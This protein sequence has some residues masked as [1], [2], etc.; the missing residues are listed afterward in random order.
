MKKNLTAISFLLQSV[1]PFKFY[2]GLHLFV[3]LYNAID[4]SLWPY[5]LKLLVDKLTITAP[6]QALP[7]T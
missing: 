3:V 1:K 4:L 5:I 2:V 7:E 6:H